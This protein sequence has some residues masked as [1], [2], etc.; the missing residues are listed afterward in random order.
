[1]K[2]WRSDPGQVPQDQSARFR[3]IIELA[4]REGFDPQWFCST[5][6]IRK[7]LRS[8]HC[9]VCN[10]C[11]ARFDHHC[12][13]VANCVGLK[14]HK[15]FIYYLIGLVSMAVWFLVAT[16]KYWK[17]N[18]PSP[19]Q[20]DEFAFISTRP[21]AGT[22][23]VSMN[24]PSDNTDVAYLIAHSLS[25]SGYVTFGAFNAFLHVIWVSCLLCCQL[26]QVLWLGMTTNERMN[27]R[28]YSHF[29]RGP[30]G[31]ISSPFNRGFLQNTIDFFECKFCG[32]RRPDQRDWRFVYDFDDDATSTTG[33]HVV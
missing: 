12:P 17:A 14:N 15:T 22:A 26:Y 5:C 1:M 18:I 16:V 6:L 13:W 30:D 31:H 32:N 28:R 33:L 10:K 4:E 25:L 9:S 2:T 3:T 29:H 24:S 8:K 23:F 19:S 27:C 20:S 7:P 11:V 21:G